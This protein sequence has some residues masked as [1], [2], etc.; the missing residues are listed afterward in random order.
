MPRPAPKQLR[1]V[2]LKQS[3]G[4]TPQPRFAPSQSDAHALEGSAAASP[5]PPGAPALGEG[6]GSSSRPVFE[7]RVRSAPSD[8]GNCSGE[9]AAARDIGGKI[10]S[11]TERARRER[12][13][14]ARRLADL[15]FTLKTHSPSGET[16]ACPAGIIPP[17]PGPAPCAP[18][19]RSSGREGRGGLRGQSGVLG[20]IPSGEGLGRQFPLDKRSVGG[21][22][23]CARG[24]VRFWPAGRGKGSP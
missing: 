8:L 21:P 1:D 9:A 7:E 24:V 23:L 11:I 17:A 5:S 10:T 2:N 13:G 22:G 16:R 15:G 12:A 14:A 4:V 18:G 3:G 19:R 6:S 20:Q